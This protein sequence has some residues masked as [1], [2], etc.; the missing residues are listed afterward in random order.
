MGNIVTV[1]ANAILAASVAGVTYPNPTKPITLA[2]ITD[3]T[4]PTAVLKGSEVANTGGSTYARFDTTTGTSIW[5]T[6]SAGSVT[7]SVGTAS[8]N[9]MPACTIKSIELWDS[10]TRV[11]SADGVVTNLSANISSATGNFTSADVGQKIAATGIPG[12]FTTIASVTDSTHAVL[13]VAFTGTTG[14]STVFT[15]TT[16]VRRWFGALSASKTVNAGDT[17]TFATSSI[18]ITLS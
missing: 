13:A 6:A 4:D 10:A 8:F 7:N 18:S 14:S 12:G 5:G 1:E 9:V 17:V 16:P 2:L 11:T 15:I 3:V